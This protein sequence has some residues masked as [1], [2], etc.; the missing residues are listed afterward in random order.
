[1]RPTNGVAEKTRGTHTNA[2]KKIL[3]DM[4]FCCVHY[5]TS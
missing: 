2:R 5:L 1:M 4:L 3:F